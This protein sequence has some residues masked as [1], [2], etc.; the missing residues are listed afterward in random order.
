MPKKLTH[1]EYIQRVYNLTQDEYTVL[2]EYVNADVKILTR[3]NTCGHEWKISPFHFKEGKRCPKCAG[4]IKKTTKQYIKELLELTNGEYSLLGEYNGANNKT[5]FIH[6]SPECDFNVFETSPSSIKRGRGCPVC[7]LKRRSGKNHFKYNPNLSEKDR[8]R[9]V[10]NNHKYRVWRDSILKE[11]DYTCDK[12]GSRGGDLNVHHLNSWDLFVNE[13]YNKD[14]GVVLC[15]N[16]HDN[17]H[18]K[19]GYGKNTK[20]QYYEFKK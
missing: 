5:A 16:C 13:R 10:R 4:N 1:E 17:F 15:V 9:W 19:Y 8:N 20:E 3:H 2:E 14:N 12:C 6:N 18:K 7:A 11:N